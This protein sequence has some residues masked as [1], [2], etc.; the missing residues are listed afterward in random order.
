MLFRNSAWQW[1]TGSRKSIMK[2][3][4]K[5]CFPKES[6]LLAQSTVVTTV[7]VNTF[8]NITPGKGVQTSPGSMIGSAQT[9]DGFVQETYPNRFL[10]LWREKM[11]Q[12]YT[13]LQSLCWAVSKQRIRHGLERR[14]LSI[15]LR[16]LKLKVCLM[17]I[18]SNSA[19]CGHGKIRLW[20]IF[21]WLKTR[22][23]LTRVRTIS[24]RRNS[25]RD[26]TLDHFSQ[27][28]QLGLIYTWKRRSWETSAV[29][30]LAR[31][32]AQQRAVSIAPSQVS[33]TR[34]RSTASQSCS[35]SAKISV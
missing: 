31:L 23:Y 7:R 5:S 11:C 20:P 12:Q 15:A 16:A 34:T 14:T 35:I 1:T 26:F 30:G 17:K 33:S 29:F 2:T 24:V 27:P 25:K 28:P 19:I 6:S 18:L 4:Q 22:L 9:W 13:R 8:K 10:P 3:Q 21:K 32:A